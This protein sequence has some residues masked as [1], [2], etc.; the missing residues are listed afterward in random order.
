M[1]LR[2][3]AA[4]GTVP[5]LAVFLATAS[6]LFRRVAASPS[7][8]F[9]PQVAM[10]SSS[11][12]PITTTTRTESSGA[13]T[14]NYQPVHLYPYSTNL[15]D[16]KATDD[17]STLKRIHI[18]R[19]AEGTHNVNKEYSD[20]VNLDARLTEKGKEQC[21]RLAQKLQDA[22][23]SSALGQLL[24]NTELVVTS[25]LTRCLQTAMLSFPTLTDDNEK[26]LFVAHESIRETVNYA[27][28]RRRP[29]SELEKHFRDRVDFGEIEQ[30]HDEIWESYVRRSQQLLD[31]PKESAELHVVADRARD[32]FQ[33]A[34]LRPEREMIVCT[35]SAFLRAFLSWGQPGGVLWIM[36][37][38][39]DTRNPKPATETPVVAYHGDDDGSFEAAIRQDYE[40]CELRSFVAAYPK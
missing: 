36:P 38:T 28:D 14:P 4:A 25:P 6:S 5:I 29:I 34:K 13:D 32:F 11:P 31:K 15:P 21:Q 8:S 24:K 20:M 30:D 23:P 37:Q 9:S 22:S 18:V 39:L 17:Y 35:H 3:P 27:C 16:L 33:W 2:V 12:S 26:V 1:K 10:V 19:H 7:T 40:N